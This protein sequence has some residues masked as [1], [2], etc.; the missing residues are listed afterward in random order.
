[1]EFRALVTTA[2]VLMGGLVIAQTVKPGQSTT[3]RPNDNVVVYAPGSSSCG[4]W[5]EAR[6]GAKTNRSDVRHFQFEAF[7]SGFASAYN[8]YV[9]DVPSAKGI[10]GEMD[11]A[12][13]WAYLD[14]YCRDNPTHAFASAANNLLDHLK[15]LQR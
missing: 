6:E 12:G 10:M 8:W 15:S 1:M 3:I 9:G 11:A 5:L 14:K 2:L 4:A 13:Q 7:L